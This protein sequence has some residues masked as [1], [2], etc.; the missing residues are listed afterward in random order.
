MLLNFIRLASILKSGCIV[1]F[2]YLLSTQTAVSQQVSDWD[3]AAL[4]DSVTALLSNY[5]ILHNQLTGQADSSVV[6]RFM[7]LFPNPRVQVINEI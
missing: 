3:K 6:W 4:K 7:H 5:Q 2:F 1:L